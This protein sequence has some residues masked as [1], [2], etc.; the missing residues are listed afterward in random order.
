MKFSNAGKFW[1]EY[2]KTN[3]KKN[4]I[5]AYA[6]TLSKFSLDY[7]DR[8][9]HDITSDEALSFLNKITEGNK[10]QTKKIR[11]AHLRRI[12]AGHTA[13][14]AQVFRACRSNPNSI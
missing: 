9:I 8:D 4:T 10:P 5:R 2:H 12:F 13:I 7:G 11:Y 1:L 3:S 14:R 6:A